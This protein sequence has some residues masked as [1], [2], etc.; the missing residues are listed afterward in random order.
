MANIDNLNTT[1]SIFKDS[2]ASD[3]TLVAKSRKE[4]KKLTDSTVKKVPFKCDPVYHALYPNGYSTT[5][6]GIAVNL[7][8]DGRTVMLSEWI[9]DYVRAK[10]TKKAESEITKKQRNSNPE[11]AMEYLGREQV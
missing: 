3:S 9:A 11:A 1:S 4:S 8:F 10:I 6:Q 5:V 2:G 7:I